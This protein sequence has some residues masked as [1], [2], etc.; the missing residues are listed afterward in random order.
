[1]AKRTR[2]VRNYFLTV[3]RVVIHEPGVYEI[4]MKVSQV[5]VARTKGL[6][7]RGRLERG[8]VDTEENTPTGGGKTTANGDGAAQK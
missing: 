4:R 7:E 1:M 8:G 6:P 5:I 3:P 2:H